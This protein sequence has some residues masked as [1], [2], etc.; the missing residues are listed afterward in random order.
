MAIIETND[1]SNISLHQFNS[2]VLY[3]NYDE[4]KSIKID[5]LNIRTDRG[6]LI[7]IYCIERFI[8]STFLKLTKK[9]SSIDFDKVKSLT[10]CAEWYKNKV[11]KTDIYCYCFT[12]KLISSDKNLN[13]T[14]VIH[15][16]ES[17]KFYF[18]DTKLFSYTLDHVEITHEFD[19]I[20]AEIE[21]IPQQP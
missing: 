15:E 10:A 14:Y 1:I 5:D 11:N 13:L 16:N 18:K 21:I 12:I 4:D 17:L 20:K 2:A 6:Y 19:P 9:I 8:E 3:L 7:D